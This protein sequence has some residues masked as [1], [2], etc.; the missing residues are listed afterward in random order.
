VKQF[1]SAAILL[2]LAVGSSALARP[3]PGSKLVLFSR[4]FHVDV[5]ATGQVTSVRP[6]PSLP[7]PVNE[8]IAA[9]I[10]K[11][12]FSAPM[13]DGR[14]VSG[15]TYLWTTACAAPDA[16]GYRF[17]VRVG[18]AGPATAL[19]RPV[20]PPYPKDAQRA[21]ISARYDVEYLVLP[22]GTTQLLD[23]RRTEGERSRRFAI[24][25]EDAIRNWVQAMRFHPE[26][27]EGQTVATRVKTWISFS[28]APGKPKQPDQP[29]PAA[30]ATCELAMRARDERDA[31]SRTV[32]VDTPFRVLHAN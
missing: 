22:D 14:P 13:R 10:R 15:S 24:G 19:D 26:Q 20:F 23:T 31:E 7:G 18:A 21:G 17:A 5:D 9:G 6:D 16:D 27:L 4:Q 25:F 32:A 28:V 8:A 1:L 12:R 3:D 30:N 11:A 29:D 2:L